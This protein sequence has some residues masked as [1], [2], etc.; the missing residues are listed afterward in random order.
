MT[1]PTFGDLVKQ[2]RR[3]AGLTQRQLAERAKLDFTY[4]SKIEGNRVPP[5]ARDSIEAMATVLKLNPEERE[6]LISLAGRIPM[7]LEQLV[8][9]EPRARSLLRS[10]QQLPAEEQERV[11]ARLIEQVE[12]DLRGEGGRGEGGER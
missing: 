8:V 9:R 12:R 1:V 5:P 3:R 6:G 11:L 10:I 7:D 4:V 2:Y